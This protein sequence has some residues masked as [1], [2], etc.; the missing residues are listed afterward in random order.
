MTGGVHLAIKDCCPAGPC[1]GFGS[2]QTNETVTGALYQPLVLGRRSGAPRMVGGVVS[3]LIP[4]TLVPAELP[5]TSFAVP[6]ALWF[7]PSPD[8]VIGNV[9]VA[10]P[11]CCPAGPF[12]GFGSLH[13]N[14]TVTGALYQGKGFA[15]RS[16]APV[17]VGEVLSILKPG[18][19][20]CA[21]FNAKSVTVTTPVTSL[22]SVVSVI[23]P[24][25][26]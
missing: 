20:N 4:L 8:S 11:D 12:A 7:V 23:E 3:M 22:P 6:E 25:S 24:G 9:Q 19:A 26:E 16:G 2:A 15:G 21:T 10:I 1:S 13:V 18:E 14:V 17:T 5:A